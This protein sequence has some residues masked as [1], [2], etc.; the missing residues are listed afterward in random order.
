MTFLLAIWKKIA[1]TGPSYKYFDDVPDKI[2]R[3]TG[4]L[5]VDGQ[6]DVAEGPLEY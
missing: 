4:K 3:H 5:V 2:Q 6:A 1:T